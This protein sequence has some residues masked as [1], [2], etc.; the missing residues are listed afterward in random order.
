MIDSWFKFDNIFLKHGLKLLLWI[1]KHS[2]YKKKLFNYRYGSKFMWEVIKIIYIC[3][4]ICSTTKLNINLLI[5]TSLST[6]P[7]LIY[8][9]SRF[10][11]VFMGAFISS[12]EKNDYKT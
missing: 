11:Y 2:F 9:W 10:T 7:N 3:I 6:Y 1:L 12:F 4:Y 5:H 8:T